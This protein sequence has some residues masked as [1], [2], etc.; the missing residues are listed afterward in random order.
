MGSRVGTMKIIASDIIHHVAHIPIF[1]YLLMYL[2]W[3]QVDR[4]GNRWC[5]PGA[6]YATLATAEFTGAT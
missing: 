2:E 4:D 3:L 5:E 6:E 1:R